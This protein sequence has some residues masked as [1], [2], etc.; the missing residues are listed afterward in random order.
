MIC[1]SAL[2]IFI[3]AKSSMSIGILILTENLNFVP[4]QYKNMLSPQPQNDSKLLQVRGGTVGETVRVLL[5]EE[6]YKFWWKGLSARL[7]QSCVSS[8]II[9][10][11]YEPLKRWSL[12]EEYRDSVKW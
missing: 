7:L 10:S 2:E 4:V 1:S 12:K 9:L 8:V 6:G 5:R 3:C 11:F